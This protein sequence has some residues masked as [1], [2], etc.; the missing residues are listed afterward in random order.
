MHRKRFAP[1]WQAVRFMPREHSKR[2][3]VLRFFQQAMAGFDG[4]LQ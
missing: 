2:G 1:P 4:I 3:G